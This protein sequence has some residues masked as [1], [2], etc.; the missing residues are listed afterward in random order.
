MPSLPPRLLCSLAAAVV[1]NWHTGTATVLVL[2]LV[3]TTTRVKLWC[4]LM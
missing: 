3:H 2:E 4:R 1:E